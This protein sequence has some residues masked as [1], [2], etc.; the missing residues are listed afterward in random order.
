LGPNQLRGYERAYRSQDIRNNI[1]AISA[2]FQGKVITA[3]SASYQTLTN[4]APCLNIRVSTV[5]V[6][7]AEEVPFFTSY[8]IDNHKWM[9]LFYFSE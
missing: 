8:L 7:L 1:Q 6:R 3:G 2:I 4:P 9:L 5:I